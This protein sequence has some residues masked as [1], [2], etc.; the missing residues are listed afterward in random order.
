MCLGSH[1]CIFIFDIDILVNMDSPGEWCALDRIPSHIP[2]PLSLVKLGNRP[3][4][5]KKKTFSTGPVWVKYK[6]IP[7]CECF[8]M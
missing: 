6:G 7:Q 5:K 4:K 3:R 8:G 2:I 1:F